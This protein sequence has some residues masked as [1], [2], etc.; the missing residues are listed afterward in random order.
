[1]P[2]T[3]RRGVR[4]PWYVRRRRDRAGLGRRGRRR[5]GDGGIGALGTPPRSGV[6]TVQRERSRRERRAQDSA[7]PRRDPA[8][9]AWRL[10]PRTPGPAGP[11]IGRR[12][13]SAPGRRC[14]T[15]PNPGEHAPHGTRP[16]RAGRRRPPTDV[17]DPTPSPGQGQGQGSPSPEPSQTPT[18]VAQDDGPLHAVTGPPGPPAAL[19]ALGGQLV[20]ALFAV[21]DT[22]DVAAGVLPADVV[23]R[24]GGDG[25]LVHAG[26][27]LVQQVAE[28]AV[29]Q[30]PVD[31][32]RLAAVAA[33]DREAL[34]AEGLQQGAEDLEVGQVRQHVL[35]LGD[36]QRRDLVDPG[37]RAR[38]PGLRDRP[39]RDRAGRHRA[40]THATARRKSS[41][42][43]MSTGFTVAR[44][45]PGIIRDAAASPQERSGRANR[46]SRPGRALGC[47]NRSADLAR[48]RPTTHRMMP[49]TFAP[50]PAKFA[51]QGFTYDDVLLVPAYSDLGPGDADTTTRLSRSVTAADPAGLRRDG[52]GHRGPDGRRHGPPGRGRRTAPQPADRGAGAAGRPGQAVR[53]GHG[54][55]PGDVLA[56]RHARRR[57][58]AVRALPHLR[59]RR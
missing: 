52:H 35:T 11:D 6:G 13:R 12:R 39:R 59:V 16:C 20:M 53:G 1:M 23:A 29:Q 24:L 44:P 28:V 8:R 46:P 33:V 36:A 17:H 43:V 38:R 55:R 37:R 25:G 56:G 54:H 48:Y 22:V 4:A 30:V 18:P 40:Q 31:V 27:A 45:S 57:R 14:W 15:T 7:R 21:D 51:P 2:G 5:A 26:Q 32:V 58:A 9:A 41:A 49:M 3:R 19:A 47:G 42:P 34:D 50:E 10:T